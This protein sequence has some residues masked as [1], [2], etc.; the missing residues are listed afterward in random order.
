MPQHSSLHLN[1][2][3]AHVT[4]GL[5]ELP[6]IDMGRRH[7]EIGTPGHGHR[8]GHKERHVESENLQRL[9]PNSTSVPTPASIGSV[10][11]GKSNG[12]DDRNNCDMEECDSEGEE[13]GCVEGAGAALGDR[14]VQEEEDDEDD[15]AEQLKSLREHAAVLE[16]IGE[17]TRRICWLGLTGWMIVAFL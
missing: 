4:C 3:L 16:S 1:P 9:D 11:T 8:T 13:E 6:D 15:D 5:D 12:L 17:G 7:T 14:E 10:F 2:F